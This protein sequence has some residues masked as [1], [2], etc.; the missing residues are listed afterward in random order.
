MNRDYNIMYIQI[1]VCLVQA[2]ACLHSTSG[3]RINDIK[4]CK[5]K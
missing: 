1:K 5:G 3:E 4:Q 2:N